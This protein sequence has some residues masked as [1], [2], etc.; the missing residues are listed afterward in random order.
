MIGSWYHLALLLLIIGFMTSFIIYKASPA[1]SRQLRAIVRSAESGSTGPTGII[2]PTGAIGTGSSSS[3]TGMTGPSGS[4]GDTGAIGPTGAGGAATNTGATGVT[5]PT[6]AMGTGPSGSTGATGT[7]GPSGATGSTGQ[8]GATGA[9]GTGPTGANGTNGATGATGVTG[10]TG[11]NGTTGATGAT[12]R[13][14]ATGAIGLTGATGFT[15]ATGPLGTGATGAVGAT[16]ATGSTGATGPLGTGATGAAGATGATGFTGATGPLGTGATGAD[17]ATGAT[18]FTGATGPLGTG[19][20]GADGAT[21]VTG[22]TGA[23]GSI[24]NTGPTG[25]SG[26]ANTGNTIF[27]DSVFGNDGTGQIQRYD[28]PFATI[29]A[30]LAA[31]GSPTPSNP[32][33]VLVRPGLYTLS[34]ALPSTSALTLFPYVSL[35]GLPGVG[36]AVPVQVTYNFADTLSNGIIVISDHALVS[37]I[38]LDV[39]IPAGMGSASILGVLLIDAST[40]KIERCQITMDGTSATSAV[41][42]HAI[43]GSDSGLATPQFINVSEC[44]V[45]IRNI[46]TSNNAAIEVPG[47]FPQALTVDGGT[48]SAIQVDTNAGA[49]YVAFNHVTAAV[50]YLANCYLQG[51][52]NTASG[53]AADLVTINNNALVLGGVTLSSKNLNGLNQ[54]T[55]GHAFNTTSGSDMHEIITSVTGHAA[56]GGSSALMVGGS[57]PG[58]QPLVPLASTLLYSFRRPVLVQRLEVQFQTTPSTST[59]VVQIYKNGITTPLAAVIAPAATSPQ[60]DDTHAVAFDPA[61]T[62]A[63]VT[64]SNDPDFAGFTAMFQVY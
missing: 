43:R 12:G 37:N 53:N 13:T 22:S 6:G 27:V 8:M 7:V 61:D 21:G 33:T 30:A 32:I 39:I 4:T 9:G 24:G 36:T 60:V 44:T 42:F 38:A 18:G 59:V 26:V 47:G 25:S 64:N 55:L 15:G 50:P 58:D 62:V 14:G 31:A 41:D 2:G 29:P 17:G 1:S 3:G 56:T 51:S 20:T 11:A 35:I 34:S 23:S 16:G 5:G 40:S 63:L 45:K 52:M 28:L 54:S 49:S 10:S 48:F 19:A 57:Y 46:G